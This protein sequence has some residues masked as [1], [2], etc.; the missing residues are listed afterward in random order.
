ML[1]QLSIEL[2]YDFVTEQALEQPSGQDAPKETGA[3]EGKKSFWL[4]AAL[5]TVLAAL[6]MVVLLRPQA[7]PGIPVGGSQLTT[8]PVNT[9][10]PH[11]SADRA[12]VRIVPFKNPITP[13]IDPVLSPMPW[14][15]YRMMIQEA[16]GV[17]FTIEKMTTTYRYHDGA[18]SVVEQ[19]AESIAAA[20]GSNVL[21]GG[22]SFQ[23]NGAEPLLDYESIS[24][25]L[26]GTDAK[27]NVLAFEE[28]IYTLI[29]E[30]TETPAIDP[31]LK[32][33]LFAEPLEN[34]VAPVTDPELGPNPLW[35]YTFD[36]IE[37]AG[38]PVTL[39]KITLTTDT[40][41]EDMIDVFDA[42]TI[43]GIFGTNV[44]PG[45]SAL[46][47]TG[48]LGVHEAITGVSIVV[49][50]VDQNGNAVRAEGSLTF[51]K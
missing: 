17:D 43:T 20:V 6:L 25:R 45:G 1:K 30:P 48:G 39:E 24:I 34:P 33:D 2:G 46:P 18:I 32:A 10:V 51:T 47:W 5:V 38:V 29:P 4:I 41:T 44:L 40:T 37:R 19:G 12:E 42:E 49:E 8:D 23:W 16:A 28:T 36:I 50:G 14:W 31:S 35:L 26:D 27:G 9:A 22:T 11:P 15:I 7:A 21:H 3:P 13:E